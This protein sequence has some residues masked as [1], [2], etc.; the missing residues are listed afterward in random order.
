MSLNK[1]Q[2][3]PIIKGI[4]TIPN[5]SVEETF[6]NEILR[7]IIKMQHDLLI[8]Y[9]KEYLLTKKCRFNELSNLKKQEYITTVFKKDNAFKLELKGIIIGHFTID[10]FAIYSHHKNDFNKRIWTM[11]QQRIIS[12][13]EIL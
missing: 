3:R 4:N 6:Q 2:I 10:E 9:F 13:L 8:A 11:I 12:V 7:P 5:K 1:K